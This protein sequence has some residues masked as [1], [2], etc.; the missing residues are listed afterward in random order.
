MAGWKTRLALLWTVGQLTFSSWV[1][2]LL[3]RLLPSPGKEY[4]NTVVT[5]NLIIALGMNAFLGAIYSQTTEAIHE[6]RDVWFFGVGIVYAACFVVQKVVCWF[7]M[8]PKPDAAPDPG[9]ARR[10][11]TRF[12]E[13]HGWQP[14]PLGCVPLERLEFFSDGVFVITMMLILVELSY[15]HSQELLTMPLVSIAGCDEP[16]NENYGSAKCVKCDEDPI[17]VC[18]LPATGAWFP[19]SAIEGACSEIS[20]SYEEEEDGPGHGHKSG[21]DEHG[22]QPEPEPDL[23]QTAGAPCSESGH[24]NRRTCANVRC[25]TNS[26]P[27]PWCRCDPNRLAEGLDPC[28]AIDNN[29]AHNG[30]FNAAVMDWYADE[31]YA[32]SQVHVITMLVLTT[33]WFAHHVVFSAPHESE[34]GGDA[35]GPDG[36][37][38]HGASGARPAEADTS[39]VATPDIAEPPR[40]PSGD[41][42]G[43]I[44]DVRGLLRESSEEVATEFGRSRDHDAGTALL[45]VNNVALL[46]VGLVPY[47]LDACVHWKNLS[48]AST[49]P[50][51]CVGVI[52]F[53]YTF[54]LYLMLRLVH[55]SD[56]ARRKAKSWLHMMA[57]AGGLLMLGATL[58]DGTV[59]ILLVTICGPL[60]LVLHTPITHAW[61]TLA[62][63]CKANTRA[64][65]CVFR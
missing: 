35:H 24:S 21:D 50:I 65:R 64:G 10:R 11:R 19:S 31:N 13:G 48:K 58:T 25:G 3:A 46:C 47:C 2:T 4:R 39:V 20:V 7:P 52:E 6:H 62:Q 53:V 40:A 26:N 59:S 27:V 28:V 36:D 30:T 54:C 8:R 51:F 61:D 5:E 56:A 16:S 12:W 43:S 32:K 45:A 38:A 34:H 44:R 60:P 23:L 29:V 55:A 14:T 57:L 9:S 42:Q 17:H 22:A 37:H 41:W 18:P 15:L 49:F 33:M 1:H 63:S